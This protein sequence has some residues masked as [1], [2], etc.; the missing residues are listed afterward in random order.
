MRDID[1]LIIGS[2]IAGLSAAIKLAKSGRVTILTKKTAT[3]TATIYA[4]GGVACVVSDND[5]FDLHELDTIRAGDGLSHEDVVNHVVTSGP[6][7]IHELQKF[8][9]EFSTYMGD[10]NHLDL[11]REGGHSRRRV[12]HIQDITGQGLE[13]TLYDRAIS[14][15]NITI[16]E[17]HIAVDLI[18]ES[19]IDGKDI[20]DPG[21]ERILGAYVLDVKN[22]III[23]FLS[24]VVILATG[25]AGKVYLYTSNPDI[26]SG[27][28][29]ALAYRAGA[30][31]ANLEFVQFHPTCLYHP[32]AKNFLIS[33]ALRGEGAMLLDKR[34][35][36]F[37]EKYSQMKEMANRDIVSRAIDM[38]LKKSGDDCVFLDI[39]HK[40]P[41]FVITR[42]PQIHQTCLKFGIDITKELI[43]VVP[44]AHYMCGGVVTNIWGETDIKGLFALGET[45]CTGL[46]GANRLPSNSLLEGVVF[47]HQ[48]FLRLSDK[49]YL[50][51][52]LKNFDKV[53]QKVRVWDKG[54]AVDLQE[55]VIVSHNWD[56]IRRLMWNYVGI[57]RSNKRLELALQRIKPIL[58]EIDSHY[59]EYILT[60]DFTELRN[61]A[62]VAK[63]IIQSAF[64]RKESRGC[65]F[66]QDYPAKDD[67]NWRRDTVLSKFN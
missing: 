25:G 52:I 17:Y 5:T 49:E 14:E 1:F 50:A 56:I 63:L 29:I 12:L 39:T 2:G 53:S 10:P 65:H 21:H 9:I 67:W 22:N 13:K 26:A 33:E 32:L 36:R 43:P 58:E 57:V 40:S 46:H 27:D 11:G 51:D 23:T 7:R 41:D 31:V 59:W 8:G 19:K 30:R 47:P 54:I 62:L 15:P 42:F 3:D 35:N 45:A 44:A 20:N 60:S 37:M 16:L 18:R 48:T 66:N 24:P 28:G 34:G 64:L 6:E 55:A 4:Q 61:L 38:E